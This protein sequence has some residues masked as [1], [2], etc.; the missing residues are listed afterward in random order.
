MKHKILSAI[1]TTYV[2]ISDIA[3]LFDD[4]NTISEKFK[5]FFS[6]HVFI[7]KIERLVSKVGL[8]FPICLG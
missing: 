3:S 4:T 6:S 5:V 7:T 1:N 2:S 8:L